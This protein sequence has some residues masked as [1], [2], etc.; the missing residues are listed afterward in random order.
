M[1]EAHANDEWRLYSD[2]CFDQPK[3][4]EGRVEIAS[5]NAAQ[6]HG[7]GIP[8]VV[9]SMDD[10]AAN[11]FAAWPER[12]W[13]VA[14]DG[15]IGFKGELGPDGYLPEKVREYLDGLQLMGEEQ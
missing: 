14:Q 4:L 15:K 13:V 2:V 9:D 11:R 7:D 8:L 3:T 10:A 5:K 12:L 6:L 1:S